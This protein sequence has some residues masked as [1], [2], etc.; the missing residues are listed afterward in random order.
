MFMSKRIAPVCIRVSVFVVRFLFIAL[1]FSIRFVFQIWP[2]SRLGL[3]SSLR[4]PNSFGF[5]CHTI[6]HS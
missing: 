6:D 4:M 5:L 1:I 3:A 2:S